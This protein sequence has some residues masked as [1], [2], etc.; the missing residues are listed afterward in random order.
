MAALTPNNPTPETI[1]G[2]L[3]A[4]S[5][6][7]KSEIPACSAGSSSQIPT[8]PKCGPK[9]AVVW[10]DGTYTP[11]FGE[12][13]QRYLCRRCGL[14][15]CDPE[16]VEAAKK[17]LQDDLSLQTKKLKSDQDILRSRQICTEEAKNLVAEQR[18][19]VVLRKETFD[20]NTTLAK[21]E[22]YLQKEGYRPA[23]IKGRTRL[24]KIL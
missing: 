10:R 17:L 19:T 5:K 12:P 6:N 13:I 15:F 21:Y 18:E 8:C 2:T 23:T 16:G 22:W 9:T 20:I 4:G 7:C 14:R 24:L 11:M 3:K 1:F